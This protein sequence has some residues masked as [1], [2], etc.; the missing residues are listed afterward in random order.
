L[1][2]EILAGKPAGVGIRNDGPPGYLQLVIPPDDAQS[3]LISALLLNKWY[4]TR[5]APGNYFLE[6]Q[7]NVI[8]ASKAVPVAPAN[9][10]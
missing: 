10:R 1:L 7:N 8:A 2:L 9:F 5:A 4:D 6:H 3:S